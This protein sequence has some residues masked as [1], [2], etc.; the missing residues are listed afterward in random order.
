MLCLWLRMDS[1]DQ[2]RAWS[3]YGWYCGLML[4]A[5]CFG[6]ASWLAHLISN[7]NRWRWA[8]SSALPLDD[9]IQFSV[10]DSHSQA[11]Y[12]VTFP[13]E[14]MCS[15]FALLMVLD[16]LSEFAVPLGDSMRKRW[17]FGGRIVTA[18]LILGCASMLAASIAAAVHHQQSAKAYRTAL[19]YRAT[20]YTEKYDE[21]IAV[22]NKEE[23]LNDRNFAVQQFCEAAVFV[24]IVAAFLLAAAVCARRIR[25]ALLGLERMPAIRIADFSH[26]ASPDLTQ[27]VIQGRKL[28]RKILG[29]TV[30]VFVAFLLRCVV[31]TLTALAFVLRDYG[32]ACPGVS[33]PC[34]ASCYNVFTFITVWSGSTPEFRSTI[35][36]ISSPLVLLVM[37]WG[38][39][40]AS[41]WQRLKPSQ[42]DMVPLKEIAHH[43][44]SS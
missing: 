40:T 36:L 41:I 6:A 44:L 7:E 2:R 17:V 20:N 30:T 16:R 27:A 39:T 22:A 31:S 8:F 4:C 33:S 24:F 43:G 10:V 38:M 14:I 3:M 35:V 37:L 1:E 23:A 32:K 21:Y 25:V 11:A 42:R 26:A 13:L 18:I 12:L 34:D 28:L 19:T 29:T 15:S 5:S 9:E